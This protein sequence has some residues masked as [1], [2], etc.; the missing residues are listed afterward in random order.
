M[1]WKSASASAGANLDPQREKALLDR[2]RRLKVAT[3]RKVLEGKL[4]PVS[5]VEEHW[6][7]LVGAARAKFLTLPNKLA[8]VVVSCETL[9]EVEDEARR[10][11]N[12]ALAEL[13]GTGVP[14]HVD[15][16]SA[17]EFDDQSMGGLIPEAISGS[18]CGTG[19]VEDESGP[20]SG[21]DT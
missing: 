21:G 11:V 12:E 13:A 5:E 16:E 6:G 3:E 1:Q 10:L 14:D 9:P 20:V 17:S 15:L 2:E 18:E 7:M 4:I 8:P 19:S